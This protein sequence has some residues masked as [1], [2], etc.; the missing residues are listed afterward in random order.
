[1]K[2]IEQVREEHQNIPRSWVAV[3]VS[4]ITNTQKPT[5]GVQYWTL[6]MIANDTHKNLNGSISTYIETL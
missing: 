2:T 6:E 3:I 4:T 5:I 1:M